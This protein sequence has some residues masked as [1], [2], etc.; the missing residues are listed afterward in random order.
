[1]LHELNFESESSFRGIRGHS[2]FHCEVREAIVIPATVQKIDGGHFANSHIRLIE[3][4][5][6]YASFRTGGDFFMDSTNTLDRYFAADQ[7]V[8]SQ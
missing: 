7:T 1:M 4:S 3:V 6:D 2:F 5:S 8:G